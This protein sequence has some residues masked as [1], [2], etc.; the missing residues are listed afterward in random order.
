[1]DKNGGESLKERGQIG[2]KRS[3]GQDLGYDM[4]TTKCL[5]TKRISLSLGRK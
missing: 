3:T 5:N 2:E 1:M 4:S